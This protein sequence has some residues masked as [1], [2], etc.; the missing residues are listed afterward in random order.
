[1]F[2]LQQLVVVRI[3]AMVTKVSAHIPGIIIYNIT[4]PERSIVISHLFP[5]KLYICT[6]QLVETYIFRK[7]WTS[8]YKKNMYVLCPLLKIMHHLLVSI[9]VAKIEKSLIHKLFY[10]RDLYIFQK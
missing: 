8:N 4:T 9:L 10:S 2:R 1:M 5:V 7:L 3:V 6:Q